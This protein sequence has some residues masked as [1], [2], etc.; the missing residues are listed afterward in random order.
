[1]LQAAHQLVNR[2]ISEFQEGVAK[3]AAAQAAD[4]R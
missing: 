3:R 2:R 1:M 4:P